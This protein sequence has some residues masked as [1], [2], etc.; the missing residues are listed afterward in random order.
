MKSPTLIFQSL[1]WRLFQNSFTLI[2]GQSWLRP[3]TIA[4]C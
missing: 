1:R 3:A 4:Y 2:L